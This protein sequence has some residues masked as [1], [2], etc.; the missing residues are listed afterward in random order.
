MTPQNILWPRVTGPS[1]VQLPPLNPMDTPY[2]LLT[3]GI[4]TIPQIPFNFLSPTLC[5]FSS[6]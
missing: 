3:L 4:F 2:T 5:P 6:Y 1:H